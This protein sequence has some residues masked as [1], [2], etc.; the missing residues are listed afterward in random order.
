MAVCQL[1]NATCLLLKAARPI[2]IHTCVA[3]FHLPTQLTATAECASGPSAAA[4]SRSALIVISRPIT[5]VGRGGVKQGRA[6]WRVGLGG[7]QNGQGTWQGGCRPAV[8]R[9]TEHSQGKSRCTQR[10][11]ASVSHKPGGIAGA[12]VHDPGV[13]RHFAS[14]PENVKIPTKKEEKPSNPPQVI[15]GMTQVLP[16]SSPG[17]SGRVH[18]STMSVATWGQEAEG[19]NISK[20]HKALSQCW[21]AAGGQNH[22]KPPS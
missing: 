7:H 9:P 4:H 1:T 6:E 2:A 20:Q 8:G 17:G 5:A 21:T 19:Y 11:Q 16:A 13:A 15:T 22:T 10:Q 18:S 3:V 14:W 12:R